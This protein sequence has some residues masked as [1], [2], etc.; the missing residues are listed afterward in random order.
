MNL[1]LLTQ[2]KNNEYDTYDSAV[3]CAANEEEAKVI[4]PNLEKQLFNLITYGKDDTWTDIEYV[5]V[6][7][8][9]IADISVKE[10]TVICASFNAG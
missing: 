5:T 8:I 9:G 2:D 7:L 1:Y 4:H 3:V 10:G 6:T